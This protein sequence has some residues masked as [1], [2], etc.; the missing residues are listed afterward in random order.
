MYEIDGDD[1]R[2]NENSCDRQLNEK[3][4]RHDIQHDDT[5]HNDI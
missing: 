2:M 1:E 4:Q 3:N 5:Q